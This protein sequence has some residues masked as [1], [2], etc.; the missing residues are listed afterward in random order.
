[1]TQDLE[2]R[3]K[4]F[5]QFVQTAVDAGCTDSTQKLAANFCSRD[6]RTRAA[7]VSASAAVPAPIA[8][9]LGSFEELIANTKQCASRVHVRRS[10]CAAC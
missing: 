3:Y 1:L 8:G 6:K 5:R 9:A 7:Q 2:R 10:R 4:A